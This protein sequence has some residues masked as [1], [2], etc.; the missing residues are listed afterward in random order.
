MGRRIV[1]EI[2]YL[3]KAEDEGTLWEHNQYCL[4]DSLLVTWIP[5]RQQTLLYKML[6][7]NEGT[8]KHLKL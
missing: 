2:A 4:R 5:F 6:A 3:D 7:F 1:Q 8:S